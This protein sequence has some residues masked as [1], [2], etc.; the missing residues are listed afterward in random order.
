MCNLKILYKKLIYSTMHSIF[1]RK[2]K[3]ANFK[4]QKVLKYDIIIA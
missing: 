2:I 3:Y 1:N 4:D